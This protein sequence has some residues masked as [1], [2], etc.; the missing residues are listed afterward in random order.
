MRINFSYCLLSL[1]LCACGDNSIFRGEINE[2]ER[3]QEIMTIYPDT[4]VMNEYHSSILAVYDT[5][6]FFYTPVN[7]D[8]MYTAYDIIHGRKMGEFI[9]RGRG[10]MEFYSVSQIAN[11][12]LQDDQLH[13]LIYAPNERQILPWNI[14]ES[15]TS[16]QAVFDS[17]TKYKE[18]VDYPCGYS[19]LYRLD[20]R[21]VL[22]HRASVH[23][24]NGDYISPDVWQVRTT[25]ELELVREIQ[26][27][28]IVNNNDSKILPESF[29][30][31]FPCIKPD[32]T[33]FAGAMCW[34]PQVNIVDVKTGKAQGF[35]HRDMPNH[36]IFY[37]DMSSAKYYYAGA[38]A[39]DKYIYA[40][41]CGQP[42]AGLDL[43]LGMSELH[44]YDWTGRLIRNVRL[45]KPI[46]QIFLDARKGLLYGCHEEENNLYRYHISDMNL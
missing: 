6:A 35:H 4:V 29:Y 39:D 27:F 31:M 25:P 14:D 10:H 37:S 20:T 24:S 44:V 26:L 15:L 9:S 45:S 17:I 32:G 30:T 18:D 3:P 23:V 8:M 2:I 7:S 22:V 38:Q 33:K 43:S 46:H 12:Y 1:A 5:L 13:T 34:L 16:G 41:W 21:Q 28:D 42:L 36:Y 11:F 40:L 19:L